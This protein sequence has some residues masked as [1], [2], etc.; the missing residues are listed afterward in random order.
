MR[1]SDV[2]TALLSVTVA[3][4]AVGAPALAAPDLFM[5]DTPI[6]TGVEPDTTGIMWASPDIHV[7]QDPIPGY[8]P[9]P[10]TTTPPWW[11]PSGAPEAEFRPT[12]YGRPNYIYVQVHNPAVNPNT[13]QATSAS[14]GTERLR[15]YW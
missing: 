10:F 12:A 3:C 4:L 14:T 15:V 7:Q 8:S 5:Q 1:R 9:Q 13:H 2:L 11:P 6:D